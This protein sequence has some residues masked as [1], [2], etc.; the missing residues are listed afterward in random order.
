MEGDDWAC[1]V[2][3][4]RDAAR[5]Q[6]TRRIVSFRKVGVTYRR[7]EE[8]HT[9]QLYPGRSIVDI[10]RKIGFRVRQVRSFGEYLLPER[11]VGI[12]ARKP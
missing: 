1:L 5:Q 8:T 4:R 11:V 6:L 2:E 9:Q 3:C 10:L 7:H 12:V